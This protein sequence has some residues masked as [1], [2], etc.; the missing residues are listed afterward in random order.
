MNDIIKLR[1]KGGR[2]EAKIPYAEGEGPRLAKTIQGR[3]WNRLDKCWSY[4]LEF[5]KA[6]QL[7]QVANDMGIEILMSENVKLW[8]RE[9]KKKRAIEASVEDIKA[10]H[11][12]DLIEDRYPLLWSAMSSR[13]FQ[14]EG[15]DFMSK[16]PGSLLADDP[17]LGKTL[18]TLA[19]FVAMDVK[20]PI[21]IIAN[22]S[23]AEITWPNEIRKWLPGERVLSFGSAIRKDQ[24]GKM[25]DRM[26][27]HK[28]ERVW[29]VMNPHWVRAKAE[30]DEYGKFVRTDKGQ[31]IVSANVPE[32]FSHV[33]S[34]IVADESHETLA[35]STGNA[36]KW[37]Q[38]R[39]GMGLLECSGPKISISGTPMRGKPE[40]LF[41]QLQWLDPKGYTS[42][43]KWAKEHFSV[44]DSGYQGAMVIGEIKD[45]QAFYKEAS[46]IMI[47]RDKS[48]V[49]SD[50][51]P[52]QYAGSALEGGDVYGIWLP[53]HAEQKK[54]YDHF[55][56]NSS[57]LGEGGE[58]LNAVGALAVY[59]RM[60]QLASSSADVGTRSV[61]M[62]MVDEHGRT[63]KN[64]AGK[65]LYEVDESG[66]PLMVD[67]Q[68]LIPR[69]PS[70]KYDW[71]LEWLEERDLLGKNA[72][73]TGKVIIASQFRQMINMIGDDLWIRHRTKSYSITGATSAKAR[74]EQQDE[75]QNNPN[76]YKI[77]FVQS[78]AGGTSLTLDMADDVIILDE[79][80]DPDVQTQIEDRA[81]R[82]SRKH[83]VSIW[84]T[85]SLGTVEEYIGKTVEERNKTCR[86][87]MDGSRGVN[88]KKQLMGG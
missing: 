5:E 17:G 82:L 39:Q 16:R 44:E 35:C 77:F 2:L 58:E 4:P 52:K 8:G 29:V 38:Q 80:W 72:K 7:R 21:L 66:E 61:K 1:I 64:G 10:E 71:L 63:M 11:N 50:L 56:A 18:Q 69:L 36:K 40:N 46:R 65:I 26:F 32:L 20:G 51:P 34:G 55:V 78:K 60:K 62:P 59:T 87:V 79:M 48:T 15:V 83:N 54:Q 9:E 30:I 85:R 27:E 42:F 88:I 47:R 23:A 75:F 70:N 49:A 84:Y 19:T 86:A 6:L 81:H 67:E 31:K 53:M 22:K 25:I 76:S 13:P 41:G 37:S 14:A 24:R 57:L 68:Y 33:W 45:E 43:W 28:D 12:L 74:V 73:G 3:L